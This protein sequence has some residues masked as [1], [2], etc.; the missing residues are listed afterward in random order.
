M[1]EPVDVSVVI[2]SYNTRDWMQT[3]IDAIGAASG[4]LRV[5]VIIVDNASRDGSA[6][7][8][9]SQFPNIRLMRNSRNVGFGRAV[10]QGAAVARGE[11]V[12][13]LNPDGHLKPGALE[14][15]VSFAKSN[16]QHIIYGGRVLTPAGELDLKSCWA[17]PSLWS[18]FCSAT[19]LS[20][21]MPRSRLFDP[22]CMGGFHR[23]HVRTVDIVS[24]CMF[25]MRLAD[26]RLMGGFDE[27]YF[28]YGE[29]ADLSLRARAQ[30][31]RTC[32]ITPAAVMVHAVSASS[33]S[34]ADKMELLLNGRIALARTHLRGWKGPVGAELIV[35]GVWVRA[36]LERLGAGKGTNWTEV[37]RR[38]G[39]WRRGYQPAPVAHLA[40]STG[41]P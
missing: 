10:N 26:W 20:T 16:P 17:A 4:S 35:A 27:R 22:E 40:A 11:Y 1:S 15:L 24:G 33:S 36:L 8:I 37:W 32:A 31:G 25:L 41:S 21:L 29:D 13:L 39:N 34:R 7:F 12:L 30:T 38:R 6:D 9:A 23:D 28:V 14:A 3:C 2:I 19:L 18:L 5:E